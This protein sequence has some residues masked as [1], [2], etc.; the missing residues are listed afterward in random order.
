MSTSVFFMP[1]DSEKKYQEPEIVYHYTSTNGLTGVITNDELWF[2]RYDCLNDTEEGTYIYTPYQEAIQE[3]KGEID[4][5]FLGRIANFRPDFNKFYMMEEEKDKD[6]APHLVATR[7]ET[8]PFLCCFSRDNDSLPMWN[9]YSKN[10]R[11]EGYNIGFNFKRLK[12]ELGNPN[13]Y[14]V[15]YD[16]NDQKEILK[17]DIREAYTNYSKHGNEIDILKIR[18]TQVFLGRSLQFKNPAYKHEKEIRLIYW[19]PEDDNGLA[20]KAL[21]MNFR[22]TQDIIVPYVKMKKV[23]TAI[24]SVMIGPLVKQDVAEKTINCLLK[25]KGISANIEKSNIPIRY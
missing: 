11:Y 2:S 12:E 18:Y 6:E 23:N 1:T 15:I 8:V 3:L 20:Q 22:Q 4:D 21:N 25:Y 19:R 9:Y 16:K 14:C 7:R 10:G 24:N 5:S 17:N 13:W